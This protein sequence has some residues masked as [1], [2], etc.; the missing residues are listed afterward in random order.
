MPLTR[1][2]RPEAVQNHDTRAAV[3]VEFAGWLP[4][5]EHAGNC[6]RHPQFQHTTKA[7]S[8]YR[9][10]CS[11][12]SVRRPSRVERGID[13]LCDGVGR[14]WWAL[15]R[16]LRPLVGIFRTGAGVGVGARLRVL[17]AM[18]RLFITLR[19]R[20]ARLVPIL[21]F[22]R[23][24]HYQSQL[25][26]ARYRGLVFLPS[27]PHTYGQNPWVV[28]IEDPTTLFN[29]F[30]HNGQTY[31][32]RPADSPYFPIIKTL[33]ESDQC[34][35]IITHMRSTAALVP[36]LF[37][38]EIIRNKVFYIPLG[39]S[40]PER[41]QRHSNND[42]EPINLL[43]TNS[44]HQSPGNFR[45]RGGLEILEAF[46]IL[47][48]RYP[49]LRLTLRTGLPILEPR[50]HRIIEE[51]W[52]RVISRFMSA[53]ELSELMAESHVYLLPAARVHIVSLLQAM[54]HGLAVVASDGWGFEEYV[55]HDRNG[56][57]VKGR[58]GKVSWVDG[59]AGLVRE[60]YEPLFDPDSEVVRGLVE[61]VSRLV[62]EPGLRRRLGRSARRDVETTYNLECWNA[63]LKDVFDHM[64]YPGARARQSP[65]L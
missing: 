43:F 15:G 48:E 34:K 2:P 17:A 53:E 29:P 45:L 32:L 22:L 50:H 65:S 36:R 1:S 27:I 4:I 37:G 6:G 31:S 19:R 28:E 44:W 24:R 12:A 23:S 35:G 30:F 8:G 25:L 10:T 16:L 5:Y 55:D 39:V 61:A 52:V 3:P 56:L 51:G 63:G 49:Q 14:A 33:L 26:L 13:R 20:G 21:N 38:S 41:W 40:V 54:S 11:A 42:D 46:A 58:Y 7:P 9:F 59:P 18:I 60:D 64:L 57:I 62:E 47:H